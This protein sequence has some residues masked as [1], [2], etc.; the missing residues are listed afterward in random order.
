MPSR[1]LALGTILASALGNA[2]AFCLIKSAPST[3]SSSALNV[4]TD[5][6]TITKKEYE[7][8][9]GTSFDEATLFKRLEST[10]FLYPKHVEVIQ[11]IAPIAGAMVDE[12]VSY[13][14]CMGGVE[15]ISVVIFGVFENV[16]A[17]LTPVSSRALI[18]ALYNQYS[19]FRL[20]SCIYSY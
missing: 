17:M 10:P 19:L 18:I 4:A 3:R 20:L 7:D 9:C 12:V 13:C 6:S 8:I 14:E 11:D 5:P 15:A 2:A 1:T 16:I